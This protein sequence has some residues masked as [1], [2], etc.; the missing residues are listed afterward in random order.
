VSLGDLLAIGCV[1]VGATIGCLLLVDLI[2]HELK[3]WR[4]SKEWRP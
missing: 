4:R 3:L 1:V 2:E